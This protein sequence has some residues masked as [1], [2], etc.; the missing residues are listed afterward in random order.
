MKRRSLEFGPSGAEERSHEWSEAEPVGSITPEDAAALKGRRRRAVTRHGIVWSP[1]PLRGGNLN[2]PGT[3]GFAALHPRLRSCAP[4]GRVPQEPPVVWGDATEQI[5][6]S[7]L[8]V[9][10]HWVGVPHSG[11]VPETFPERS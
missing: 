7:P 9:A 10:C 1:P 2:P 4:L 5:V 3:G 11:H 6:H 8:L